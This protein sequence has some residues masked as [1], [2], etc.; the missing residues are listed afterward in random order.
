MQDSEWVQRAQFKE[1]N[2]RNGYSLSTLFDTEMGSLDHPQRAS[3][4]GFYALL[5][6]FNLETLDL[7]IGA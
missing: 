1:N 4:L 6:I 3:L 5:P 2:G 7:Q